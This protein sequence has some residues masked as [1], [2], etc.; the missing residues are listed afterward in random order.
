MSRKGKVENLKH[1]SKDYQPKNPGRKPGTPNRATIFNRWLGTKV[2]IP[3]PEQPRESNAKIKVTLYEACA[4]GQIE[5]AMNGNVAA[6]KELQ[7]S[8]FGKQVDKVEN[9]NLDLTRLDDDQFLEF[10]RLTEEGMDARQA[11]GI[12]LGTSQTK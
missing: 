9:F 10:D 5:A 1:F 11:Y 2:L 4:L 6:F 12:V 3:D 7:D 8:L